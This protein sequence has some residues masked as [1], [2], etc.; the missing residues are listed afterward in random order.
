MLF[1][2]FGQEI[3][4]HFPGNAQNARTTLLLALAI[5]RHVNGTSHVSYV[6]LST[7]AQELGYTGNDHKFRNKLDVLLNAGFYTQQ[8]KQGRAP[9]LRPSIP[10]HLREKYAEDFHDGIG[11]EVIRVTDTGTQ[12][13]QAD[14]APERPN[15]VNA[16]TTAVDPFEGIADTPHFPEFGPVESQ[17]L[18]RRRPVS[19]PAASSARRRPFGGDRY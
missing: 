7:L 11:E 6:G 17:S 4:S 8:G 14:K 1:D 18:V 9:I 13:R 10:E 12:K 3:M 15:K 19:P 2:E 16:G 5:L